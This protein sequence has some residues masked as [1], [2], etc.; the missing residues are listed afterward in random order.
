MS[1][2]AIYNAVKEVMMKVTCATYELPKFFAF[3][4]QV[5]SQLVVYNMQNINLGASEKLSH[6]FVMRNHQSTPCALSLF[7][8]HEA[9]MESPIIQ[10]SI[11]SKSSTSLKGPA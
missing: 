1:N 2:K 5:C 11:Q 8:T 7:T 3:S 4:F 10:T 9:C 6:R